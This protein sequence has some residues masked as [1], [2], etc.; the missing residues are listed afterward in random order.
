MTRLEYFRMQPKHHVWDEIGKFTQKNI[1]SLVNYSMRDFMY[2]FCCWLWEE[3][4]GDK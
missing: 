4:D 3:V 2:D 1:K